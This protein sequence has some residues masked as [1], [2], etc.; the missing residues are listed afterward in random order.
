MQKQ[1][2]KKKLYEFMIARK[3]KVGA[4]GLDVELWAT[5]LEK[6]KIGAKKAGR[7][8]FGDNDFVIYVG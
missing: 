1:H 7:G 3:G 5:S 6:A 2:R 8:Y 4:S